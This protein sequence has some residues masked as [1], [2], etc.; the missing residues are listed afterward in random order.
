MKTI[1]LPVKGMDCASCAN[2]VEKVVKTNLGIESVEVSVVNES[3]KIRFNEDQVVIKKLIQSIENSGYVVPLEKTRFLVQ[4]IDCASCVKSIETWV[5]ALDGV[6]SVDVNFA[7]KWVTVKHDSA[8]ISAA[9]IQ[10]EITQIGYT[11]VLESQKQEQELVEQK[12]YRSYKN[13][14]LLAVI[15]TIPVFVV[16]MF[17]IEFPGHE[18]MQFLLTTLVVFVAGRGFFR[19]G[20]Y[21]LKAKAPNMDVLVS[22]GASAAYFY[23]VV[24]M[25][26]PDL[27]RIEGQ[28]AHLYFDR[29]YFYSLFSNYLPSLFKDAGHGAHLY[30]ETAASIVTL[31][32]TG[33]MLEKR[34]TAKTSDSLKNLIGLQPKVA[35]V[36]KGNDFEEQSIDI[37]SV[38]EELLVRPGERVPLD[39]KVSFGASSVDQSTLTGESLPVDISVGDNVLAGSVNFSQSFQFIVEKANTETTLSRIIQ[40]VKEANSSK[41]PIQRLADKVSAW[42]V[43]MVLSIAIIT[44]ITWYFFVDTEFAL[45]YAIMTSVAVLIIACPCAMGL[46]APTAIMVGIGRGAENGIL[47][48][49]GAALEKLY[50]V[51]TVVLDKTGTITTGEIKV[52]H[53]KIVGEISEKELIQ[54]VASVEMLSEH[55]IAKSIV[56]YAKSQNIEFLEVDEFKNEVGVG[57]SAKVK[58]ELIQVRKASLN[59]DQ[60]D[61]ELVG[62]KIEVLVDSVVSAIIYLSDQIREDSKQAVLTLQKRGI[63][64]IMLTGDNRKTAEF[65]A[66]QAGIKTI[67][68]DVL[69]HQ[70][71][72]KIKELQSEGRKVAMVG[73][74]VNDAPSLAQAHVG[75]AMGKGTDIAMESSDVILL[76]NSL[77]KIYDSIQLSHQTVKTIKQNLFWAFFYNTAAIPIAAGVLYP[78]FGLLLSPMIGAFTMAFSDVFVIGNSIMLKYKSLR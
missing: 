15:A 55:P 68:A 36:K 77:L 31:V 6:V 69:P 50:E 19:S 23:S 7:A 76:T 42:F 40:L 66:A 73:D 8:V 4:D 20:Y 13:R 18:W 21:S 71:A 61:S 75:I 3:A 48:R 67:I 14:L 41:A 11:P 57:V 58:G 62:T 56:E 78:S 39:G 34:A 12:L 10:K 45:R 26:F 16:S 29:G 17:M 27:F 46:A 74:G 54:K 5:S 37:I 65:I 72:D 38:G 64:V 30:F 53:I 32:L 47:I 2:T 44:F 43:P 33:N 28:D 63:E 70:K 24:A 52:H 1:T 25:F 51:D 9:K 60:N 49:G 22:I 35:L 59:T